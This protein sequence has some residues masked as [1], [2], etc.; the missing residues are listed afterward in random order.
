MPKTKPGLVI[1]LADRLDSLSGLFAVGLVPTGSK[2][3]FA[4]RRAALGLVQNLIAWD[5]D[6][7][8]RAGLELAAK[9]LPTKAGPESQADALA[10]ITRRLNSLLRE[11]ELG[12]NYDVV[13]A[14]LAA[15]GHNP[16]GAARVA[17]QLSTWVARKDW[18]TI[19]PAYSRCVRITREYTDRFKVDPKKF[20]ESAEKELFKALEIAESVERAD[21]SADDFLTAF[22]PM[23]PA[24]D[25]FFEDV[26]VMVED[27][28]LRDNRLGMLQRIAAL[29]DGVA[30]LSYLEGF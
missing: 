29:A 21:G 18:A 24:I 2:D 12:Y 4:L 22:T 19:L 1:G 30:D 17:G 15:Q 13:E 23:I 10:F 14:V 25:K 6:Y 16:A 5:M 20:G 7:D 11:R 28:S 26:M 9:E 8:L 27:A 3:P